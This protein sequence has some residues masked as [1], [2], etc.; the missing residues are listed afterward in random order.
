MEAKT[1]QN[2]FFLYV[3]DNASNVKV[4]QLLLQKAMGVQNLVIFEHSEDFMTRVK[5][6]PERPEV[7]LLDIHVKPYDGFEM[8]K[9]LRADAEYDQTRIIAVTASVTNEEVEQLRT[10][11]FD[12]GIGKPLSLSTFPDLLSRI[13]KGEHVWHIV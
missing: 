7:I 2:T 3:E 13:L 11:G 10:C 12:G 4:V 8:L 1:I 9:M 6:L 5:E